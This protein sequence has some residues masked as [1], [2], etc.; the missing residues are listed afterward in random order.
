[1]LIKITKVIYA[2]GVVIPQLGSNIGDRPQAIRCVISFW[3][4]QFDLMSQPIVHFFDDKHII[5]AVRICFLKG[6][7]SII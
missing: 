4:D 3:L 6:P 1:M 2:N 7:V 5:K